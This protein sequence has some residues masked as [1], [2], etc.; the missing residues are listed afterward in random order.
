M[1]GYAEKAQFKDRAARYGCKLIFSPVLRLWS[2]GVNE[3]GDIPDELEASLASRKVVVTGCPNCLKAWE[4]RQE[5]LGR[6]FSELGW[7]DFR[8]SDR[9]H[10]KSYLWSTRFGGVTGLIGSR[11]LSASSWS[12][13][14]V[15]ISGDK[16]S[17][18]N[19]EAENAWYLGKTI[20][21]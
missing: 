5:E 16:A 4:T 7:I 6:L 15:E 1:I 10:M 11:N 20:T 2:I 8:V 3:H 9:S 21:S 19:M 18:V 12:D 13:V 17:S 14:T